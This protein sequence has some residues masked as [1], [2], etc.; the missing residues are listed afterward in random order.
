MGRIKKLILIFILFCI[1]IF[2]FK[3]IINTPSVQTR[4]TMYKV[5]F[6][7][8]KEYPSGIYNKNYNLIKKEIINK[9]FIKHPGVSNT[10]RTSSH[11]LFLNTLV[12][13]GL[14]VFL[15]YLFFLIFIFYFFGKYI[16]K[17]NFGRAHTL[18]LVLIASFLLLFIK[19]NFHNSG[20]FNGDIF[21]W[22]ILSL[23]SSRLNLD[24]TF[25]KN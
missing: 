8:I 11:N 7:I 6:E 14:Y 17:K 13:Y 5:A 1:S 20:L 3:Q 24:F 12:L 4:I 10:I 18:N 25:K 9:K 15:I 2:F 21:T 16:L 22:F 19:S 23:V